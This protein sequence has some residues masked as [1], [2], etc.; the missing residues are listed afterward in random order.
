MTSK[1]LKG[2]KNPLLGPLLQSVTEFYFFIQDQ[3]LFCKWSL[4]LIALWFGD[5]RYAPREDSLGLGKSFYAIS[6]SFFAFF[7][8]RSSF[9]TIF[10]ISLL[11][12]LFFPRTRF[13]T[14]CD[15]GNPK[16]QKILPRSS[17]LSNFILFSTRPISIL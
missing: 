3:F 11:K 8:I 12:N 7:L 15:T 1:I 13:F 4:V 5:T 2:K 6:M 10:I 9:W 16:M 14:F 17:Q